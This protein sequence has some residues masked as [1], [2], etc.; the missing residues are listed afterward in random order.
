MAIIFSK[1]S[2]INNDL[3]KVTDQVLT[4]LMLDVDSEKTKWDD[5]VS[6]I[7]N[8][9]TSTKFGEKTSSLTSFSNYDAVDEGAPAP[10]DDLQQGFS[11]LIEFSQFMKKFAVTKEMKEDGM[12]EVMQSRARNLVSSYKRTRAELASKFMTAG[13][14]TF[15]YGSKTFDSTTG[16]GK[17]LFATDHPGVKNGVA[18]Q[19]NVFTNAF[20]SDTVML[21]TLANKLYNYKNQSGVKQGYRADTIIIPSNVPALEDL[22]KRIIGS[23]QIV[24]SGNN[25]INTQKSKWTL[26]VDPLWEVASGAPYIIMSSEAN[27]ELMANLFYDRIDLEVDAWVDNDT[28]NLCYSGRGRMGVGARDWR[29]ALMGGAS[30]GTTLS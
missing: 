29:H 21:N 12:E 4:S 7:F 9:K 8:V 10:L 17:A 30:S 26:V 2:N 28:K 3:W 16:D 5:Y 27:K 23:E 19:S 24:N 20:G 15:T 25:D 18:A 1:S 13:A 6:A 22:I 11:K 14:T